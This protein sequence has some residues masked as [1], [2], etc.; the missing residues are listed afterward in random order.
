MTP[1]EYA[2]EQTRKPTLVDRAG[3]YLSNREVIEFVKKHK[4]ANIVDKMVEGRLKNFYA[5]RV[6]LEQPF[7]KE[8]SM[9][10]GQYAESKGMKV[11]KFIHWELGKS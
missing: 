9:S 11:K 2:Y 4:P 8:N 6:L 5:E 3:A 10:V 1:R 7:V